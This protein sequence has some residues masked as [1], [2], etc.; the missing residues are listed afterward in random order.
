[1]PSRRRSRESALQM[2]YQWD[3]GGAD[4][5]QV[6]ADFYGSLVSDCPR[7]VDPFAERLFLRVTGESS[8][9]D[10]M[11]Q[12]HASHWSLE[13]ISKVVRNLLRLAIS[14][15]RSE[16]TPAEVVIDETLEI[17]RR[18][19]GDES[20]SFLNGVLEAVRRELAGASGTRSSTP[21]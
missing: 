12:R 6:V 19:A 5:P 21:G 8:E 18:Y 11:I 1:M 10:A 20:T 9:L 13:R 2:I 7:P 4:P 16:A 3:L 14:E 17:G 15:I